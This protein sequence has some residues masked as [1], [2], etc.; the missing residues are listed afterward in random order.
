MGLR[1][2]VE[3]DEVS[4]GD[5]TRLPSRAAVYGSAGCAL[6]KGFASKGVPC[7]YFIDVVIHV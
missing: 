2:E 6:C 4:E 3:E 7:T 1:A 5:E